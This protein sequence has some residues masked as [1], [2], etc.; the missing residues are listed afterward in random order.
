[1]VQDCIDILAGERGFYGSAA[2]PV[3]QGSHAHPYYVRTSAKSEWL[4]ELFDHKLGEGIVT[5]PVSN[6]QMHAFMASIAA[7][8]PEAFMAGIR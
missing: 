8:D 6:L 4:D 7:E 5:K 3:P 2:N 1:V